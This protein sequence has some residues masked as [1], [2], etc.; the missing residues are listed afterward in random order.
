M[1]AKVLKRSN[2][3]DL[4]NDKSLG[5]Q[6]YGEGNDYPQTVIEIV[7][8]SG[9]GTS[10]VDVYS[11]F[12]FGKGFSDEDFYKKIVNKKGQT[13]DYI[14]DQLASDLARFGG[15][16]FHINYNANYKFTQIQHIP[17]EDVRFEKMDDS[18][19]FNRVA[20]HPDWGRRFTQ[21]RKFRKEDIEFIDLYN[22]NPEI[23]KAQVDLAGG[24]NFYKGQV[25]Y[26]SNRGDKT[27][28]LPIY[29]SRLT[30]MNTE[31]GISNISNRN[32]RNN[33][34]IAGALVDIN[35]SDESEEQ[36]LDTE[37]ALKSYQ[38]DEKSCKFMYLQVKSKEEIPVVLDFSPKNYDK[39]FTVTQESVINNIGRVFNQPPILRAENVGAGFGS[40]LMINA[41]NYYNSVTSRERLRLERAFNEIFQNWHDTEIKIDK[42]ISIDP[43]DYTPK[44]KELN[45]IPTDILNTLTINEKRMLINYDA[46]QDDDSNKSLLAEKIGVGGVQAMVSIA[47]DANMSKEQKRGM[48][49]LLFALSDDEVKSVIPE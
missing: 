37:Q 34:L 46:L 30:D 41:Y 18:G 38:G 19:N 11:K 3:V 42:Y 21:L 22:P 13:N 20:I 40:D 23:I 27:Y 26:Y 24:W 6:N 39:E 45:S 9:T 35:N 33:F 32:A 29:D 4:S 15:F 48:L 44:S 1:K 16:A 14:L 10:C 31:E 47:S 8:A 2:R 36:F 12:I 5:I 25:Y 7:D 28:P 43:L 49:K 17:L